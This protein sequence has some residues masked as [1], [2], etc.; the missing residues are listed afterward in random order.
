MKLKK[1]LSLLALAQFTAACAV[2]G[3][4]PSANGMEKIQASPQFDLAKGVFVNKDSKTIE[5]GSMTK[6][7]KDYF[8]GK[9]Q[10]IPPKLLPEIK[11][12]C[13]NTKFWTN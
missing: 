1:V 5:M 10:R 2:F 9:Q 13:T 3:T 8:F 4:K 11:N 6:M 7:M 12:H